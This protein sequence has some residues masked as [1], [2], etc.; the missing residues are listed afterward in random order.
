M[1]VRC[2][3]PWPLDGSSKPPKPKFLLSQLPSSTQITSPSKSKQKTAPAEQC[4]PTATKAS[5]SSCPHPSLGHLLCGGDSTGCQRWGL[6]SEVPENWRQSTVTG[7]DVPGPQ[8]ERSA[9]KDLDLSPVGL[10]VGTILKSRLQEHPT[11]AK[12]PWGPLVSPHLALT[13]FHEWDGGR[14]LK[15]A[16]GHNYSSAALCPAPRS[17]SRTR[18]FQ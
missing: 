13:L 1:C 12:G 5:P 17:S 15:I 7:T 9:R 16:L 6:C 14:R 11:S 4:G 2:P 10:T 3:L 18:C 8:L